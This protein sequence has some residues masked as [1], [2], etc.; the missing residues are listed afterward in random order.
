MMTKILLNLVVVSIILF[1]SNETVA[2]S[3]IALA[4][5]KA[6]LQTLS[7]KLIKRDENDRRQAQEFARRMGVPLRRELPNGKV[8]ELQRISP[9]IGPIFYITNNVDAADTVSTD[10]VWPGG[11]AGLNLD[12][13]DM[14]VGEWDGGAIYAAHPDFIGRLTQVDGA[15]TV[16]NHSTHVAGT[17][18]GSGDWLE[19]RSRGMAYAAQLN[20]YDWNSDTAEMALA[21]SN[22]MLVSNHSYGIA[23]GWL[24]IGGI[25]PDNW[26]W[27]GGED[28]SDVEDP[29][30]GY[31]D[32]ETQLWDQI[33]FDAPYYLIVKAVGNDR[34]DI[35]P[36][37]GEEYT[38]ID[39]DGN[40]LFTSTLPRDADCAPAGYDCLPTN[41]VAKNVLTVGAVDDITGGYSRFSGPS[42]VQMAAFSGWGPTD[43]GRIKPDVVGNGMFL[44]SAWSDSPFYAAAAGTSMSA[45][46]VTGS[47][48][49]L[50]EHYQN[51]YGAGNFM[52]AAT[53]KAL[54][55]HTA[56][57]AGDADGPDYAFG[58]GLLNTKTAA[59]VISE[60]GGAH[61]IIEGDLANGAVDSVEITVTEADATVTA[62]LDWT[63]PPG[64]PVA[65][66]LDAP[67][68]ML[69]NDLD[70]RIK[71]GPS[72]YMPWVLNPASPASAASTGDNFRDN[73][74]QVVINSGGTGSYFVE[75]SH[76]GT[77]LNSNSQSY[78]LIISVTPPPPS[79][80]NV[81]IDENFSGGLP[82]GWSVETISGINWTINAPVPGNS[83]LDN[84]TGG[85]GNFAMVDNDYSHQTVTSLRMPTFDLS[86]TDAVVLR[87][88]S[89]FLFDFLESIN[90]DIST[91]GG[92]AWNNLWQFQGFNPSGTPY[93]LDLTG[94]AAGQASV[95]L[96]FRFDSEG[97]I[98]G[99]FWQV[100]DV[101]LEVFG[102]GP[103]PGNLPG[104]ASNPGP[105]DGA[106][107]VSTNAG[108]S[109]TAGSDVTSHDVYFGTNPA[110][111]A[112]ES[113]G[114]QTSTTF[115]PGVLAYSTTYHWRIDEVNANG[116]TTGDIWSFTT[117]A[118]PVSPDPASNPGPADGATG[119]STG[120]G[121]SW[122]TGSDATSHNVYFGTN[123]APGAGESEGNQA[124]TT[125]DPGVLA[126]ATTYYWRTDEVNDAG[127]TT[128]PVWS[129]TTGAA[130]ALPAFQ[131]AD[132]NVEFAVVKGPRNR[133]VATVMVFDESGNS[134]VD[135]V[136]VSGTF[137]GDW[138]GT[139]SGTSDGSG[140]AVMETPAVKNGTSWQFCVDTASKAGWQFD[141]AA[142][143]AWLCSAPPP[144]TG[145]IDGVVTDADSGLPVEGATASA[146]TGQSGATGV[147]GNYT[148]AGVPTG[149]RTV[150]VSASG[151]DSTSLPIV[152]SDG[153]PSMLDFVL[154][155]TVGGGGTG[156]LK[157]TV[158]DSSGTK[159]G[160]VL[161][162]VQG[163]G[164]SATTN[165]GGKYTIQNVPGGP[166]DVTASKTGFSDTLDTVEIIAGSTVTLNISMSP[167]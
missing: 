51:I 47:L 103:P 8:L 19:P 148:L 38:V 142:S 112:G 72:T 140:Q 99:N 17:L 135:G 104:Q 113:Q 31:Y 91:D 156:A 116:T 40:F 155:P 68:I 85:L 65:L 1:L 34:T 23:A 62:T 121:L 14:T 77:L 59:Q 13:S 125:F 94:A 108:L 58:W 48:L 54:A 107:G 57:E 161:V 97:D 35:G 106:A 82:A 27:I 26:W 12:G 153:V 144:T 138:S 165:K 9:D 167:N 5:K 100:D 76:K 119:V 30:F 55:I 143:E 84:G 139:R 4:T 118:E 61:R 73:V 46:N 164:Q 128:G 63:D 2:Q 74:E 60:N 123:P 120:A 157:G 50:Q 150:T 67:D 78:S 66:S 129:F 6:E 71:K 39:Q 36:A 151:Y 86:S 141:E 166:Q 158:K 126:Y 145:S 24:Y 53:L 69:V 49:L 137:S 122:T 162:E 117:G 3:D 80:S 114:N 101:E 89:Y 105:A 110:P 20:A 15:T 64:T 16:S 11:S 70:L 130:P 163:G 95:T 124:G 21:A 83:R 159:L 52:R 132:V 44:I 32:S 131:I 160:G 149:N 22:G 56:D 75:V 92:A 136:A 25:A 134:T 28:P 18:I 43:D 90:V 133:G 87:F 37:P 115:D 127:T 29:N 7:E 147:G 45:P 96:R 154:T 93:T 79:G 10:E 88:K 146:D 33:A 41:S 111:G 81:L 98:A 42:S 102:G 152:V 109:W